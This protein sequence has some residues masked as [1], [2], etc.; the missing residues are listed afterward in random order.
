LLVA[1]GER[2]EVELVAA[3]VLGL[4]RDGVPGDEIAVVLRHPARRA[5]LVEQV[6]GAYGIPHALDWRVPLA[7]T[8]LG[9]GVLA[10]ARCAL[11]P[12]QA[13]PDDLLAY[14]RT[15]GKLARLELADRLEATVRRHVLTTV[16]LARAAWE[17]AS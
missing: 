10:L 12:E 8:A 7:H 4:L 16:A 5:S 17:G 13:T 11:T 1:G 9:R 14:L 2:A 3:T 6:F 15:P